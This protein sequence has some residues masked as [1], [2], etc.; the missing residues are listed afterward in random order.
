VVYF[1]YSNQSFVNTS[2]SGDYAPVQ[3]TGYMSGD[4]L[5]SDSIHC[6]HKRLVSEN[7]IT[8]FLFRIEPARKYT[9]ADKQMMEGRASSTFRDRKIEDRL[10][11]AETEEKL[12]QDHLKN[13]LGT[14][15]YYGQSVLLKHIYSGKYICLHPNSL[16]RQVGSVRV[17]FVD[18]DSELCSMKILPSS[19][20]KKIG[21]LVSYSDAIVISN[22]K[23][24]HYYLHASEFL[25]YYD[26]GLEI[27]GS[28][29]KTEWR[30]K[31]YVS[32]QHDNSLIS[33]SSIVAP[34]VVVLI[35]NKHISGYLSVSPLRL[36][37]LCTKREMLTT[38]GISQQQLNMIPMEFT[39]MNPVTSVTL[40]VNVEITSQPSFYAMWE[41]QKVRLFDSQPVHYY[42]ETNIVGSAIRIRNVATQQYL[43]IDPN[44]D[45]KL[46]LSVNGHLD[47]CIFYFD[48]KSEGS[49]ST[50]VST[51]ELLRIKS[52]KGKFIFP[53]KSQGSKTN[54]RNLGITNTA[55]KASII[56][57]QTSELEF[58]F[59]L[60]DKVDTNSST[61]ELVSKPKEIIKVLNQ[62]SSI[63]SNLA[64]F[65]LYL[66]DWGM[67]F[68]GKSQDSKAGIKKM[69]LGHFNYDQS[70]E[71]EKELEI[72]VRETT[73]N[74]EMIYQYLSSEISVRGNLAKYS[75][76]RSVKSSLLEEE[77]ITYDTKKKLLI[78]LNIIE[79]LFKIS[80]LIFF[81]TRESL[82]Y[83]KLEAG[84]GGTEGL[85]AIDK[86]DQKKSMLT[87]GQLKHLEG[88]LVEGLPQLIAR[89][90]L[91]SLLMLVF[92]IMHLAVWDNQDCS[93]YLALKF[94]FFQKII[95][96]FP[97]EAMDVMR[98]VA[99]NITNQEDEYSNFYEP[100]INMLE[101]ISEKQGN[102]R[103]QNFI[104]NTLSGL[105]V[106]EAIN[107]PI[108]EFQTK[109]FNHLFNNQGS[110]AGQV[111]FALSSS[112]G[113]PEEDENYFQVI[114]K[115][116]N[117][118]F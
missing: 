26:R 13:A 95:E 27:N 44:D 116:A 60:S 104:L 81:K 28:E 78:D 63:F 67:E 1:K 38:G 21:D 15:I 62:L 79:M 7:T 53:S 117:S 57:G 77:F 5:S 11:E 64:D 8:K 74:L 68:I 106:D 6:T 50:L 14:P 72:E 100:W 107:E 97:K 75:E 87:L 22:S 12:Y 30:P 33:K 113:V 86:K 37:P 2:S 43:A 46:V 103:K 4:G 105:I 36:A 94:D 23:E 65:Y 40:V 42:K 48:S 118:K 3:W 69:P 61:F 47:E 70:F 73:K 93:N 89:H 52:Y 55:N 39:Y 16:A 17:G 35:H 112:A 85:P 84:A 18:L 91:D 41:I 71:T 58:E 80:E 49:H 32:D 110:K 9:N 96:F 24:D 114:F 31:L 88:D 59:R 66:Q 34:G 101:D 19:R 98:E 45:S 82:S 83:F 29:T 54:P 111:L 90:R 115:S 51:E 20:I 109:I 108:E 99:K 25:N 56:P 102:I 10:R 76:M 92:K